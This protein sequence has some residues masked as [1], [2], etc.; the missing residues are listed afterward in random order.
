M[1]RTVYEINTGVA[2][3]GAGVATSTGRS[4]MAIVGRVVGVDVKYF[5]S[6]PAGTTVVTLRTAGNNNQPQRSILVRTNTAT[7]GHFRPKEAIHDSSG[8]AIANLYEDPVVGD[9]LE[10]IIATA[11]NGDYAI[12]TVYVESIGED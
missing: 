11:N 4:A 2:A 9:Q 10:A 3:G 1:G 12:V 5:D 7:D 8:A 6:P